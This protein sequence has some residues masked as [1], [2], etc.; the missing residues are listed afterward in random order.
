MKVFRV[1]KAFRDD[2]VSGEDRVSSYPNVR[3]P[4]TLSADFLNL[5]PDAVNPFRR[6]NHA[7]VARKIPPKKPK[8]VAR[9]VNLVVEPKYGNSDEKNYREVAPEPQLPNGS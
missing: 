9:G 6:T 8:P 7:V 3:V 4:R 2:A 1:D 5:N